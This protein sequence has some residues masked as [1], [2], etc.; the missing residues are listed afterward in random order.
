MKKNERLHFCKKCL[1]KQ[2]NLQTGI[3]CGLTEKKPNFID[4]CKDFR[5]DETYIESLDNEEPV[6]HSDAL[7]KLSEKDLQKFKLEQ[8]YNSA[9]I[10][11]IASGLVGAILWAFITVI[12]NYQIG[13]MAIAI[14]FMIGLTMRYFGKGVDQIFGITGGII[15]IISCLLGNF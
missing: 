12:T 4:E 9:L 7:S 14:G 13:Y 1:N 6:E 15:A 5:L 2:L 11:G 3:L 8:N 10:T